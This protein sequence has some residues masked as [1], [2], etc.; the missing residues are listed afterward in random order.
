MTSSLAGTRAAVV[1]GSDP[2]VAA[3]VAALRSAGAQVDVGSL[4][5]GPLDLAV[6]IADCRGADRALIDLDE[7]AW[8]DAAEAPARALL[9]TMQSAHPLLR[10]PGGRLLVVLPSAA[11]DGA[12]GL[13]AETTG[14]E[15]M[16]LLAKS[17]A[18]RWA[19]QGIAVHIVGVRLDGP[20]DA[21]R[22]EPVL[23]P[24]HAG[25]AAVAEVVVLL[26]AA[27]AMPLTGQ[28]LIVDG[29][30]LMLP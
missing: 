12:A 15:A 5:D 13:V 1:G 25:T 9:A 11:L 2:L 10:R 26:A 14:W 18:R 8:D 29:G 16:R 21:R 27:A 28:T 3:T 23:G 17:A 6:H 19:E 24:E 4:D 22:T 20:A 30:A 7:Q